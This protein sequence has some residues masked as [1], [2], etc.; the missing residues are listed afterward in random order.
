MEWDRLKTFYHVVLAQSFTRAAQV[1]NITQSAVS[2]QI[3]AIEEQLGCTIFVRTKGGLVLTQEGQTLFECVRTMYNNAERARMLIQDS[4]KEPQ[5]VIK[6]AVTTGLF[7]GY[8]SSFMSGFL[9]KYPKIEL[10]I[11]ARNQS[12]DWNILEFDISISPLV[13]DRFNLVHHHLIANEV[14]LYASPEYLKKY[15]A[16]K[17]ISDLDNHRL[18]AFGL[19]SNHPFHKMNW[20]L[21]AGMKHGEVRH[22]YLQINNPEV[23]LQM[24]VEGMGICTISEEHPGLKNMNVV[25]VLKDIPTPNVHTFMMYPQHL[26]NSPRIVAFRNYYI[27]QFKKAY[28]SKCYSRLEGKDVIEDPDIPHNNL[29]FVR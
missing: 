14:A 10:S 26:K 19:Q 17:T 25:R 21:Y 5:G 1:I 16:P 8:F 20:H 9:K 24:A 18:I 27:Q 3:R 28:G 4:E 23:R 11:D 29:D 7:T 13:Q 6:L 22:P 12:P 15:G 2:R